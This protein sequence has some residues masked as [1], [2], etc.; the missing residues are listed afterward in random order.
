MRAGTGNPGKQ[1]WLEQVLLGVLLGKLREK[2]GV[3]MRGGGG[4]KWR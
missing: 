4:R 3:E 2:S 1:N